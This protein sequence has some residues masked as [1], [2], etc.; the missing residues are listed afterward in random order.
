MSARSLMM[1]RLRLAVAVLVVAVLATGQR[2][3]MHAYATFASWPTPA[4]TFYVNPTNADVT[5]DAADAALQF[6]MDVWN[7]Q[8]ASNFHYTYGGRVADTTTGNDGRNVVIFRAAANGSALATTY[9]WYSGTTLVDADMVFWDQAFTFFTGT[10]GCSGGAYI[11]DVATHEL[12]HA[13]GLSHSTVADATMYPSYS[14]CSQEFRT[15]AADDIAGVQSLYGKVSIGTNATPTVTITSPLNNASFLQGTQVSFAGSASDAED[16]LLT[17]A[18]IWKSDV[19]GT[20]GSGG[21][22]S[23]TVLQPGHH[24]ITASVTDSGGKTGSSTVG[25]AITTPVTQT[26]SA[27]GY[28]VKGLQKVDLAWSNFSSAGIDIYRNNV[29]IMTT[30]NDGAETDPINKNGGASYVYKAC[31]AGSTTGCSNSVTVTF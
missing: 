12:G 28:K 6:A 11:E 14:Y 10:S 18:L 20:I 30:P 4:A 9:S 5:Q 17:S 1:T 31:P 22:F 3:V 19:Q 21:S 2:L 29:R 7:T 27:R 23:T 8:G 24:V 25:I 26:L 16:G 13:L 15:L